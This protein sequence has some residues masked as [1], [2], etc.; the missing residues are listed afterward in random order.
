VRITKRAIRKAI[1][2][3]M[4]GAGFTLVEVL[5]TC[6]TNWRMNPLQAMEWIEKEMASYYPL[7]EIKGA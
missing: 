3:Q 2:L 7:G 1:E 4:Q 5:S 6:P